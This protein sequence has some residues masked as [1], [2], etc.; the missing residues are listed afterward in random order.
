[1]AVVPIDA[2]VAVGDCGGWW[3]TDMLLNVRGIGRAANR[4]KCL[5]VA[6]ITESTTG[7]A[8]LSSDQ[9]PCRSEVIEE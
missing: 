1:V 8:L 2:V 5:C 3:C 6:G 9:Q 7:S 4:S